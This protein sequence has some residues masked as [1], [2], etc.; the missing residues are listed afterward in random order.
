M[1]EKYCEYSHWIHFHSVSTAGQEEL[2]TAA[3]APGHLI[4]IA[5]DAQLLTPSMTIDHAIY[6]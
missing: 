1:N 2:K 6:F 5:T 4:H 3:A